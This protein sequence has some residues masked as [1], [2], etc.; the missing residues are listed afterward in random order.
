MPN[1]LKNLLFLR[2]FKCRKF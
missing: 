2:R 1:R